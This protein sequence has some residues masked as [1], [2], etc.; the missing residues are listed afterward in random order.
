MESETVV[1]ARFGQLGE[2]GDSDRRFVRQQ[3][4]CDNAEP[5]HGNACLRTGQSAD[6]FGWRDR[7]NRE[8]GR[9]RRDGRSSALGQDPR[10]QGR[11]GGI[12]I[13][14]RLAQ[15]VV[16]TSVF[17]FADARQHGHARIAHGHGAAGGQPVEGGDELGQAI[18][19]AGVFFSRSAP[20]RISPECSLRSAR[21]ASSG[22]VIAA[23][24]TFGFSSRA[25][26]A[27][28][29]GIVHDARR[30]RDVYADLPR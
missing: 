13:M 12:A 28:T 24:A 2:H 16:G 5:A 7:G 21:V 20:A 29:A 4:D 3:V 8:P 6:I 15:Q 10:G 30:L 19:Q 25:S 22:V 9:L 17:D 26:V 27:S 11:N 1:L 23:M 18:L 14:Q